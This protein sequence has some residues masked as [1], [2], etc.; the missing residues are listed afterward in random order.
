MPRAS[1][2]APS[3]AR[4]AT[5]RAFLFADLRGYT[6]FVET[7]GDEAAAQLIRE[8]RTLVRR[9][10]AR[11]AGVEIKTEGDSFYLVFESASAAL[12]CAVG[13]LRRAAAR[14]TERSEALLRIGIGLHAGDAVREGG[15]YVG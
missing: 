8:Y 12:E 14:N 1:S 4:T 2:K 7:S 15:Q 3:K 6:A 5:T 10:V 11:V 9:E 13:I